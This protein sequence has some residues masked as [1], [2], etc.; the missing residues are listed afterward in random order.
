MSKLIVELINIHMIRMHDLDL[1]MKTAQMNGGL[2]SLL[3]LEKRWTKVKINAIEHLHL[4]A[5]PHPF[6]K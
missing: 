6:Y 3:Q 4:S 5:Q 1:A 2:L